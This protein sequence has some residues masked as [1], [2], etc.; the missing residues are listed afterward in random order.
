MIPGLSGPKTP[1]LPKPPVST[2]GPATPPIPLPSGAK[3]VRP[4]ASPT[5][6][7]TSLN[8]IPGLPKLAELTK[9]AM[10][11]SYANV[12]LEELPEIEDVVAITPFDLDA[13][14]AKYR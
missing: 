10:A 4:P 13:T 2:G 5:A 11:V 14:L 3:L 8:E 12:E 1:Q 9:A 6:G 7:Q